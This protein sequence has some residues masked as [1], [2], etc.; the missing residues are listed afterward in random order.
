[1]ENYNQKFLEKFGEF[2]VYIKNKFNNDRFDRKFISSNPLLK[3]NQEFWS[4]CIALRNI[5]SHSGGMKIANITQSSYNLF[6]QEVKKIMKPR[7]ASDISIKEVYKVQEKEPT[8]NVISTM[9][10]K[11]YTCTPIVSNENIVIGVFTSHSLMKFLNNKNSKTTLF[12]KTNIGDL[13]KY[14]AIQHDSDIEYKFISELTSECD[15][16]ELFKNTY[17]RHKRLEAVFVT[18][19]GF[20]N[21]K[22]LGIITHWDL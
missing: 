15:I 21:G 2:E 10:E 1:M 14:C 9:L 13:I 11:N 4:Q 18:D 8:L 5:Y 7:L 3:N 16:K 12:E 19:N 20:E 22:L 6:C 17:N